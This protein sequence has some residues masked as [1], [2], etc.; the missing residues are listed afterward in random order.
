[1]TGSNN[2]GTSVMMNA[3]YDIPVTDNFNFYIGGGLG[4]GISTS[5]P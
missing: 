5:M 1:M 4:G 2:I 3:L